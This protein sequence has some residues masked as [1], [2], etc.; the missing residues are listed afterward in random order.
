MDITHLVTIGDSF[1]YC[2]GLDDPVTQGWP[3]LVAK[4]YN[5]PVVNLGRQGAGN[6]SIYRRACEYLFHD[7]DKKSK[8]FFIVAFTQ[9]WRREEWYNKHYNG[10]SNYCYMSLAL[11]K[12][13]TDDYYER[14]VFEQWNPFSHFRNKIRF[15][16]STINLFKA[17]N[18][19]YLITDYADD[20]DSKSIHKV[21]KMFANMYN[22]VYN[23]KYK[24]FDFA[25]LTKHEVKTKCG[26]D[27]LEAQSVV[28][29]FTISCIDRLYGPLN[30]TN[31]VNG[32]P[33]NFTNVNRFYKETESHE[34]TYDNV[35]YNNVS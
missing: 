31:V 28:S 7:L 2:Q 12:E 21:E 15:M 32:Y 30:V 19:P 1:T 25:K 33:A 3:T 18:I 17:N 22:Y 13:P 26:H 14:A 23:D 10:T 29:K 4:H 16:A 20:T 5:L 35:W 8:P 27:G 24:V 11:R 9:A 34:A 6:D